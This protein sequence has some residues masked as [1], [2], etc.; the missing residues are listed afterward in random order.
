LHHGKGT[1]FNDA[2]ISFGEG[3]ADIEEGVD[4]ISRI[5]ES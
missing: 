3:L 5:E 2:C 4:V 1:A